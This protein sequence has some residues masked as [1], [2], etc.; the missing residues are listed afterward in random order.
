M[1]HQVE[2]SRASAG[3]GCGGA[4]AT[5]LAAAQ[6]ALTGLVITGRRRFRL[7]AVMAQLKQYD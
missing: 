2:D 7:A 5:P 6:P 3:D 1:H 4:Q